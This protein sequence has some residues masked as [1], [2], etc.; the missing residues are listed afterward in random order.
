VRGVGFQKQLS[1]RKLSCG[2]LKLRHG[3]GTSSNNR[4]HR[5]DNSAAQIDHSRP[6]PVILPRHMEEAKRVVR[7]DPQGEPL[8]VRVKSRRE[9]W[10]SSLAPLSGNGHTFWYPLADI[11]SAILLGNGKLPK[12]LDAFYLLPSKQKLSTLRPIKLRGHDIDPGTDD[13]F[14]KAVEERHRIK[15]RLKSMDPAST[16]AMDLGRQAQLLKFI[17]NISA[18][19]LFAEFI[20]EDVRD[21]EKNLLVMCYGKDGPL[22]SEVRSKEIPA[23][24]CFPPLAAM[25]TANARLLMAMLERAVQDEGGCCLMEA[26]DSMAIPATLHGRYGGTKS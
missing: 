19:G 15:T 22:L 2:W 7:I 25:V 18:Y 26:I 9:T 3:T 17:G 24:Y 21:D 1:N 16:E 6:W 10:Y 8:P 11:V 13:F 20:R 12:I 14:K 4:L 23:S 5:S